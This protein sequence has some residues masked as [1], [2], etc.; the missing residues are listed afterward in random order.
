MNQEGLLKM[1]VSGINYESLVD[2]EGVRT[3]VFISGCLHACEGCHNPLTHNFQYG[4][5]FDYEMQLDLIK[6]VET[7]PLIQGIT[8][9]GGDPFFSANDCFLFLQM[10]H[11]ACPTKNIWIYSGF[12]Y[13]EIL[14]DSNKLRLLE[15]CDVLVDGRFDITQRDITLKFRGS[16]NQNVI[17]VK[18]SLIK[19]TK[20]LRY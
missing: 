3:T 12:T 19:G 14:E 9:S 17:N 16:K 2:G 6:Y 1:Y 15:L 7:N 8:L 5:P 10:F 18:D 4:K 13:E 20:I 11:H